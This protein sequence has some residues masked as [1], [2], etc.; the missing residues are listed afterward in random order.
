MKLNHQ[1]PDVLTHVTSPN[2]G[3]LNSAVVLVSS[4]LQTLPCSIKL[5]EK[6]KGEMQDLAEQ[7]PIVQRRNLG[8]QRSWGRVSLCNPGWP[9]THCVAHRSSTPSN[10]ARASPG[11]RLQAYTTPSGFE[12]CDIMGLRACQHFSAH[13]RCQVCFLGISSGLMTNPWSSY[14]TITRLQKCANRQR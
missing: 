2:G 3:K 12:N 13:S 11:L 7:L 8:E 9:Q 5:K 1:I 4:C 10:P 6:R 14:C